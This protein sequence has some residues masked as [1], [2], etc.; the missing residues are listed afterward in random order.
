M[1]G[2]SNFWENVT[3]LVDGP[4]IHRLCVPLSIGIESVNSYFCA[5]PVPTLIDV[6]PH[7]EGAQQYLETALA[8]VGY[9]VEDIRRIIVT[10][11]HID[12][13]GSAAWVR[14]R[15]GAE[16]WILKG[17]AVAVEDA[18]EEFEKDFGY[19]CRFVEWAG[20]PKAGKEY[21]ARFFEV[22]KELGPGVEVTR[23]L[24]AGDTIGIGSSRFTVIPV[25]GH[26]PWCTLYYDAKTASAFTGDF[27]IR[28]ISSN[29][30]V[31]RPTAVREGYRS[32]EMYVSSLRK[33]KALGLRRALPGHGEGIE[34]AGTRID[35]VLGSVYDRQRQIVSVLAEGASTPYEIMGRVFF[36]LP[37]FH[38]LLGISEVVGHLEILEEQGSVKRHKGTSVYRLVR[39]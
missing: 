26:T 12:H 15:S 28:D 6:P 1:K 13:F 23:R 17:A 39:P 16:V 32:L 7:N 30:V 24:E 10:H 38:V 4:L 37:D 18:C 8:A 5:E 33:V 31:R 35:K 36:D 14:S 29:A 20:A 2:C 19:Y 9:A 34:D 3:G 21:L 27:L 11:P 25:P 22:L